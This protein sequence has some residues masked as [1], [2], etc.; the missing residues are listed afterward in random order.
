MTTP[1][2]HPGATPQQPHGYPA[3]GPHAA[4]PPAAGYG[5]GPPPPPPPP[6]ALPFSGQSGYRPPPHPGHG[7]PRATAAPPPGG[8][9]KA[10]WIA[11]GIAVVVMALVVTV[12][13]V[14]FLMRDGS[15]GGAAGDEAAG[16][17]ETG[18]A[19][20]NAYTTLEDTCLA[21]DIS[22]AEDLAGSKNVLLDEGREIFSIWTW[23]CRY[24]M[25]N[26][27]VWGSLDIVVDVYP[28]TGTAER[29]FD[30]GLDVTRNFFDLVEESPGPWQQ[31]RTFV[32][33]DSD[34]SVGSLTVMD[35]VQDSNFAVEIRF[36]CIF[37]EGVD[38]EPE[39]RRTVNDLVVNV[40]AAHAV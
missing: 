7:P 16:G 33:D 9:G 30:R 20:P 17:G 27:D 23:S 12:A 22:P 2:P 38:L 35:Q 34:G 13:G 11:G 6:G 24:S 40:M 5:Y 3:T 26:D 31:G 4:P 37:D 28:D 29:E 14:A 25:R 36:H 18:A 39:L 21:I 10:G 32:K 19:L 15:G 8:A 1:P